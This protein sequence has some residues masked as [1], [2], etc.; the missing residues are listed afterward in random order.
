MKIVHTQVYNLNCE[1]DYKDSKN[2][3]GLHQ[4]EKEGNNKGEK[5]SVMTNDFQKILSDAIPSCS[6]WL[7]ESIVV[8]K[9]G[10]E[11]ITVLFLQEGEVC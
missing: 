6:F 3:K 5:G 10:E 7:T 11:G 9:T 1:I 4:E 8:R 2:P